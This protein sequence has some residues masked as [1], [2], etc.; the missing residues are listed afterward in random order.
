LYIVRLHALSCS[1]SEIQQ[2]SSVNR[3]F[4]TCASP[5]CNR[6]P[7]TRVQKLVVAHFFFCAHFCTFGLGA[8]FCKQHYL[9]EHLSRFIVRNMADE[10]VASLFQYS[11]EFD[12]L[13][14][15]LKQ[16]IDEQDSQS[17]DYSSPIDSPENVN[18]LS[19]SPSS[20]ES[21]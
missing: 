6:L 12:N 5:L 1:I 14:Q 7:V 4:S 15:I 10:N 20:S 9:F 17:P 11:E 13:L 19:V 21:R 8:C 2:R 16:S 18:Q 3:L